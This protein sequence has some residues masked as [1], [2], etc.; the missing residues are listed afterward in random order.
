M[1]VGLDLRCLPSDGSE[2]AGVAHA[3]RGLCSKLI[4][5]QTI[6]WIAYVVK[7]SNWEKGQ[8]Y[9][10][11]NHSSK[12]LRRAIKQKPCDV[13]FVP[14]GA[15]SLGIGVPAVP[16]IHDLIIFDHPEWFNQKWLQRQFTTR[17][18]LRGIKQAPIVFAVSEYTKKAIIKHARIPADK[19]FVTYEGGEG[20]LNNSKEK[21][22][23]YCSKKIGIDHPFVLALGTVEPRKNLAMLIRAWKRSP[24][25]DLVIAGQDGWKM[26]EVKKEMLRL[27][28][29]Q[30]NRF[31]QLKKV[32]D[33][34]KRQ[35]L[36]AAQIVAVPSLDEGF[37]LVALEAMQA[38]TNIIAS[39]RGALPEVVGEAGFLL[40]P[41]DE[42]AWAS[43][44]GRISNI[45]FGISNHGQAQKF[46]WEKAADVVLQ[47]FK[48]LNK[49]IKKSR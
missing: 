40:D 12:S 26:E 14:S 41:M 24:Q 29:D 7:G 13:L 6:E 3:A 18:F 16:W 23:E 28:V 45:E 42:K 21:S 49:A 37:G 4:E 8:K 27:D 35:L 1:V 38:G 39:N 5:D 2:G 31:H 10:L 9:E 44:L 33:E 17:I 22:I 43:A 46:S 32:S 34:D 47:G 20:R 19:I 25:L 30:K 11:I 15:V 36:S 48:N